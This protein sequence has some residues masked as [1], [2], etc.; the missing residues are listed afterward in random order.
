M[1]SFTFLLVLSAAALFS[2]IYFQSRLSQFRARQLVSARV[3]EFPPSPRISWVAAPPQSPRRPMRWISIVELDRIARQNPDNLVVLDL[4]E[5]AQRDSFPLQLAHVLP[6]Q[7]HELP[8]I[9]GWLPS[10]Q[11]VV[12]CG[13]SDSWI[14][15][16]E[17]S[18]AMSG[19]A[20]F[21]FLDVG[22]D[23]SEAA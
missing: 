2:S 9:L 8:E 22:F 18:R 1:H 7:P 14:S 3:I 4:R 23:H 13:A 5:D 17:R 16:I 19:S 15:T 20:T 21:Y 10:S 12:F 11:S 6:V